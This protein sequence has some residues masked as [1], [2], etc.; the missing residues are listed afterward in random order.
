MDIRVMELRIKQWISIIEEQAKS[1]ISKGDWCSM[2]DIDHTTFSDGKN[3]SGRIFLSI[4]KNSIHCLCHPT[5]RRK[6]VL[7]KSLPHRPPLWKDLG[8]RTDAQGTMQ[9]VSPLLPSASV[10]E[11]FL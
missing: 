10:M 3:G 1:G 6:Q 2:H 4:G 7:L 11:I 9:P 5:K 8:Q